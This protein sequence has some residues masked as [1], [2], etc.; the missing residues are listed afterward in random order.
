MSTRTVFSVTD[1]RI[2][3]LT[4][5][6]VRISA[7]EPK[8]IPTELFNEAIRNGCIEYSPEAVQRLSDALDRAKEGRTP[9][10]S[11]EPSVN[12]TPLGLT[13]RSGY[14]EQVKAAVINVVNRNDPREITSTGKP[15][16]A[17]AREEL[18]AVREQA[19]ITGNTHQLTTIMLN[20]VAEEVLREQRK[21]V[22]AAD[23]APAPPAPAVDDGEEVGGDLTEA[24][25]LAGES[26]DDED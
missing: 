1:V 21:A 26:I 16:I 25:A 10:K 4:G 18:A 11:E 15:R 2:P 8:A 9:R 7:G 12:L 22:A 20:E 3:S 23:Y 14:R 24:L 13:V 17:V 5:H 6:I 19:G